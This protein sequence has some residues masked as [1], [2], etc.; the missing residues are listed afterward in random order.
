MRQTWASTRQR[1]HASAKWPR[2]AGSPEQLMHGL[3]HPCCLGS[4]RLA[5]VGDRRHL[6]GNL[7]RVHEVVLFEEV[8]VSVQLV[9]QGH[10]RRDVQLQDLRLRHALEVLADGAERVAMRRNH[11]ALACHDARGDG[12]EPEGQHAVHG[13]LQGLSSRQ[14]GLGH[15]PVERIVARVPRIRVIDR[16][17]RDV[18]AP[19]PD[20]DLFV[21]MLSR[22][23]RLVQA[24]KAAIVALIE[25]PAVDDWH[26]EV[27]R[28]HECR[29]RGADGTA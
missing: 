15:V 9:D 20:L 1:Y 21:A 24:L 28:L 26:G 29:P 8:H 2:R 16:R 14:C 5:L 4:L 27:V 6:L 19:T 11:D 7:G 22:R 12:V 17:G 18:V 23:L 13:Q 10:S 25:P 3:I